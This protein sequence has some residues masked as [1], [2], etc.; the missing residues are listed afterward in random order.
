M[1]QQQI[2]DQDDLTTRLDHEARLRVAALTGGMSPASVA[3]AYLDWAMHLAMS[4]GTQAKLV[5]SGARKTGRFLKY[6]LR[7]V[8]DR[9]APPAADSPAHDRRFSD[10][11]WQNWPFNWLSQSFLLTRE[12]CGEA[13]RGI[14]GV[15]PEH[16]ALVSFMTHQGL[17]A[18]S[19]YNLP[20]L[21][22]EVVSRTVRE[23]G[24][25]LKRGAGHAIGDLKRRILGEDAPPTGDF[26]VGKDLACTPGKVVF[27]NQLM[28]LIQYTPTTDKV[29]REPLFFVPPWIMKYYVLDLSPRNSMVRYMVEQG[30]TVFMI[31]W[32]NPGPEERYL[33]LDD[34]VKLGVMEGLKAVNSIVPKAR[35]NGVGYCAGGTLLTIAAAAMAREGD[36]R[37][38]SVTTF[39]A[40][41]DC[42]EPGEIQVFLNESQL[43]FLREMMKRDGYMDGP[44]FA[45]SFAALN[46][47][48][49]VWKPLIDRYL[50]GEEEKLI[51]L[52][53]WN[54]DLTRVPYKA[55]YRWIK[56]IFVENALA[57]DR[58][59]Y[60]G[61]TV[62]LSDLRMP[63]C[64]VATTTDHVAPWKSVYKIHRLASNAELTFIL[65]NGGH[66]AGIAC[67]PVHPRREHQMSTRPPDA[68]Y[69]APEEWAEKTDKQPGSWWPSWDQWLKDRTEGEPVA[70]PSMGKGRKYAPL[71]DAPGTY[72]HLR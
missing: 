7:S 38:N 16:E 5:G 71:G 50:L 13:T 1:T 56:E 42:T 19:P 63:L 54:K 34:Y 57:E 43:T 39:T 2:S 41:T 25:N 26:E 59:R 14:D 36:Q 6:A 20:L 37:L 45:K 10:E 3:T 60:D 33:D 32:K 53:A 58:Y 44:A 15:R 22:A 66:N 24:G 9:Q 40:Q 47:N 4:P 11:S 70:P 64:F 49:L 35:V 8:I 51:D 65:T 18:M 48:D 68:G 21:N 55:H 69:V 28:E 72:V 62:H 30:H 17:D 12:W 46:V 52:M 23:R 31:S 61:K 29:L 27:R 67:G